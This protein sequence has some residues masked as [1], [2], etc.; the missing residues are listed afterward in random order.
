MV[1]EPE[2]EPNVPEPPTTLTMENESEPPTWPPSNTNR[3]WLKFISP[4]VP[5][6]LNVDRISRL[7]TDYKFLNDSHF[8]SSGAEESPPLALPFTRF[9]QLPVELRLRI[10]EH[11]L[12]RQRLLGIDIS[13]KHSRSS[14]VSSYSQEP[15]PNATTETE[16]YQLQNELGNVVSHADYVLRMH[17][18]GSVSPLL[19]VNREANSFVRQHYR[20]HIPVIGREIRSD[21]KEAT[22]CLC[23]RPE[24]DTISV[25]VEHGANKI[26]FADFVHD[27]LAY[28]PQGVGIIHIAIRGGGLPSEVRLPLRK[29][30]LMIHLTR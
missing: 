30:K 19:L 3:P 9:S 22:T 11:C 7:A 21:S 28:D 23:F 6:N 26:H 29:Y 8:Q 5:E 25:N 24:T 15:S 16:L 17:S 10:W 13:A 1:F 20:V 4:Q 2:S 12:P 27:A 18:T 14:S